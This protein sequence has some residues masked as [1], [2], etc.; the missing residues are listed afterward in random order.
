MEIRKVILTTKGMSELLITWIMLSGCVHNS[1]VSPPTPTD[2]ATGVMIKLL[3]IASTRS[4]AEPQK[5]IS[6]QSAAVSNGYLYLTGMSG[7]ILAYRKIDK[8]AETSDG[9][10]ISLEELQSTGVVLADTPSDAVYC[11]VYLNLPAGMGDS[12]MAK[13]SGSISAIENLLFTTEDIYDAADAIGKVPLRGVAALKPASSVLYRSEA[14][15]MMTLLA[16]RI[17]IAKISSV[18]SK[19]LLTYDDEPYEITSFKVAGIFINNFFHNSNLSGLPSDLILHR[20]ETA[21]IGTEVPNSPYKDYTEMF[22]YSHLPS[23]IA[24]NSA[25]APN[26]WTPPAGSDVWAYNVFP[27]DTADLRTP[28]YLPHIIIRFSELTYRPAGDTG[29][30]TT[31]NDGF[32]TV[33]GFS[34]KGTELQFLKKGWVYSFSDVAFSLDN[35]SNRPDESYININVSLSPI[36]WY[37]EDISPEL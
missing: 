6:G 11:Y 9:S 21:F 29:A 12:R 5:R 36:D 20:D 24:H 16:A 35:V 32:I 28:A 7:N 27:N 15:V 1:T 22:T 13:S 30:G 14:N 3:R 17:E 10:T 26:E 2:E 25:D 23:G 31:I 8:D 34:S 33:S 19:K 18:L 37:V 4:G